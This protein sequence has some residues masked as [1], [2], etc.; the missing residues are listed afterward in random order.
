MFTIATAFTRLSA[1]PHNLF[2]TAQG[3]MDA[4]QKLSRY[5]AIMEEFWLKGSWPGLH[6]EISLTTTSG[7]MT[8][9]AAYLRLD[10]LTYS[11]AFTPPEHGSWSNIPL[12]PMQF[13]WQPGGPQYFDANSSCAVFAIDQ[14]DNSSGQREY[15]LTG[16][17][18]TL[19]AYTYKG[20]ARK[21]YVYAT[22]TSD[23]V[24]PDCYSALE[25]AF[26]SFQA[27]DENSEWAAPYWASALQALDDSMGEFM[28]GN[29]YGVLQTDPIIGMGQ[30]PNLI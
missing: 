16:D 7:L 25:W 20:F 19:D 26:R 9:P 10:G 8:L 12:Q 11:N 1:G 4:T 27:R 30:V 24:I 18:T 15:Q 14:G 28:E 5:N 13:M 22:S 29:E 17:T 2:V 3:T 6:K 21:R 23:T